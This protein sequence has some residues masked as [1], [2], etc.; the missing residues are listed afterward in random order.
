M[1]FNNKNRTVLSHVPS[2]INATLRQRTEK[3]M[4]YREY[5]D[6]SNLSDQ[7]KVLVKMA[8]IEFGKKELT[9]DIE[10]EILDFIDYKLDVAKN[11]LGAHYNE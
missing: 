6:N 11:L 7:D 5:I 10:K 9:Q 2:D 1:K 3:E 8:S 4:I